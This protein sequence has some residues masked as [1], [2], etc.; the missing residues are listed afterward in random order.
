ME[1]YNK[2]QIKINKPFITRL[3]KQICYYE[4]KGDS[5]S[6]PLYAGLLSEDA[7]YKNQNNISTVC[8]KLPFNARIEIKCKIFTEDNGYIII[9][10]FNDETKCELKKYVIKLQSSN[11]TIK[12]FSA[13][14]DN[15]IAKCEYEDENTLVNVI[16]Y[17]KTL[18]N[19]NIEEIG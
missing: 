4:D 14:Y 3:P 5:S 11:K 19:Y 8:G 17:I 9:D 10:I 7:I 15:I 16:K 12:D 2:E 6:V 18:T 1:E 13:L